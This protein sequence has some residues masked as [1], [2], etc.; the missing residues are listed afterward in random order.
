MPHI[1]KSTRKILRIT[2]P[3]T[4]FVVRYSK[5][6][7]SYIQ[8]DRELSNFVQSITEAKHHANKTPQSKGAND[9][10]SNLRLTAPVEHRRGLGPEEEDG[11]EEE[12]GV[13]QDGGEA[14]ARAL[15]DEADRG[16]AHNGRR[17]GVPPPPQQQ[18]GDWS[19]SP[20]EEC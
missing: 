13:G 3:Y 17:R 9:S 10:I 16:G 14:V 4:I 15:E 7:I 18:V 2:K 11:D 20:R 1:L 19:G 6:G 12:Q 5:K 8:T